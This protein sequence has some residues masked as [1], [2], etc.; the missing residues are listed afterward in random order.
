M[1][2]DIIKQGCQRAPNRAL[3]YGTGVS[4]EQMNAPFIGICS[5]FTDLIPGHS[6]MRILER[7]AESEKSIKSCKDVVKSVLAMFLTWN[8]KSWFNSPNEDLSTLKDST[9]LVSL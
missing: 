2:S 7:F 9:F 5:S 4:K 8:S 3:I 1:R 6:G